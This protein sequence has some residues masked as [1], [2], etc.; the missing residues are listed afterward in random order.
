V[1][2]CAPWKTTDRKV[3]TATE[4][5][6]ARTGLLSFSSVTWLQLALKLGLLTNYAAVKF[7]PLKIPH[8][9]LPPSFHQEIAEYSWHVRDVYQE[10]LFQTREEAWVR[11]FDTVSY[12]P[13]LLF[14]V[15]SCYTHTK[16]P[17]LLVGLFHSRT[18]NKLG[19]HMDRDPAY[20]GRGE[21][22]H[23]VSLSLNIC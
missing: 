11:V 6:N 22:E 1:P 12:A 21:V 16:Y 14:F 8:F 5:K 7:D 20:S 9:C 23:K 17:V 2:Y 13:P 3:I 19:E 18:I 10:I 15:P 4:I